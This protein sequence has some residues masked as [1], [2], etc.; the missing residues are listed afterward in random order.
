MKISFLSMD[1]QKNK[2]YFVTEASYEGNAFIFADKSCRDT[3][4]RMII[5]ENGIHLIRT[6]S[7]Q[8]EM[9]F[10]LECLT[11]GYYKNEE[12]LEFDFSIECKKLSIQK[13]RI[14]IQYDM[15]LEEKKVSSHNLSMTILD[16]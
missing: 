8:M 9:T 11:A 3:W 15:L 5:E 12:G 2:V 13:K 16:K 7:I 6:G 1:D 4:I 14:S 10:H